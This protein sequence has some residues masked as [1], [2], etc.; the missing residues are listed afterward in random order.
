MTH[1]GLGRDLGGS[2]KNICLRAISVNVRKA[3]RSNYATLNA[4]KKKSNANDRSLRSVPVSPTALAISNLGHLPLCNCIWRLP[5]ADF[6]RDLWLV[7]LLPLRATAATPPRDG[8]W[9]LR[10][11][12]P[13]WVGV[14]VVS[15]V[16]LTLRGRSR[17]ARR[18]RGCLAVQVLL[19]RELLGL[20]VL[21]DGFD[22]ALGVHG[23]VA[24]RHLHKVHQVF[25]TLPLP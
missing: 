6:R 7:V 22:L 25:L 23:S 2:K 11:R 3:K 9:I 16:P 10:R 14:T 5:I 18:T 24:L 4:E 1:E 21:P 17:K 8:L 19:P 13:C 20:I 15:K 12:T